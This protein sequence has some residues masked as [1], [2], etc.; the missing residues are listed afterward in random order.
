VGGNERFLLAPGPSVDLSLAL[1]GFI[2]P[3][4]LSR[5]DELDG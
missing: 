4:V 2:D 3:F 5:E 1:P